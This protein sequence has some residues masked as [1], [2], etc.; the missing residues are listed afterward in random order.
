M[1]S[2]ILRTNCQLFGLFCENWTIGAAQNG[3]FL[4]SVWQKQKK[5]FECE[6][7]IC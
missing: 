6:G 4:E 3:Y 1:Y 7:H 5:A 2:V